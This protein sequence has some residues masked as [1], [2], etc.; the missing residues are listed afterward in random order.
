MSEPSVSV[1]F[2]MNPSTINYL[3]HS[4][5]VAQDLIS[6]ESSDTTQIIKDA[7]VSSSV[8]TSLLATSSGGLSYFIKLFQ[9]LDILGNLS[10][11]NVEFG[12]GVQRVFDFVN[13]LKVPILP[14]IEKM[15]PL[16]VDDYILYQRGQRGKMLD[17]NGN[18]FIYYGQIMFF[19][20][21]IVF[22]RFLIWVMDR[23]QKR[24]QKKRKSNKS[25]RNKVYPRDNEAHHRKDE[26]NQSVYSKAYKKSVLKYR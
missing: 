17:N 7:M 12:D 19:V 15:S 1:K 6:N 20:S 5:F 4:S 9:I 23:I 22:V 10:K 11:L 14:F 21:L 16:Q 18:T 2:T 3:K 25:E 26:D 8:V 24:N 13:G